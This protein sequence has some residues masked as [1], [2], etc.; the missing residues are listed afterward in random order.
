MDRAIPMILLCGA[1][2]ALGVRSAPAGAAP[3]DDGLDGPLTL[4][5]ALRI[6]RARGFDLLLADLTV[7]SARANRVQAGALANPQL[8]GGV[9]HSFTYDP[10]A[11]PGCSATAWSAGL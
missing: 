8:S 4:E 2:L 10:A 5:D 9:G 1:V 11:C 6:F 3:D 7:E